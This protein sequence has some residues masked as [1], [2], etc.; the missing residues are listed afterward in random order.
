MCG[1]LV[2]PSFTL[3]SY[4]K[5]AFYG[6]SPELGIAYLRTL[7]LQTRLMILNANLKHFF[8]CE[9]VMFLFVIWIL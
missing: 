2:K 8:L 4:G 9:L 3:N 7:N 6:A 1:L 5:R